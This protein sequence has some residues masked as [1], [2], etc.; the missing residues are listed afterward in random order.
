MK[1]QLLLPKLGQ[2]VKTRSG[3]VCM[4]VYE[5]PPLHYK[6]HN[7][8]QPENLHYV[9]MWRIS[10]PLIKL[11]DLENIMLSKTWLYI[12]LQKNWLLCTFIECD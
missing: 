3:H 10:V 12:V 5:I 11:T 2:G 9:E 4:T 7:K 1:I 6:L 8:Y